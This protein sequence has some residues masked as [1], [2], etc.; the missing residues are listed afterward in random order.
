MSSPSLIFFV[1]SPVQE[2]FNKAVVD[3][4]RSLVFSPTTVLNILK[5]DPQLRSDAQI[6]LLIQYLKTSPMS[7]FCDQL[8]QVCL[9]EIASCVRYKRLRRGQTLYHKGQPTRLCYIVMSGSFSAYDSKSPYTSSSIDD[10]GGGAA[11]DDERG[12]EEEEEEEEEEQSGKRGT[13]WRS[14]AS[15]K[16]SSTFNT[17]PPPVQGSARA[18]LSMMTSQ[19]NLFTTYNGGGGGEERNNGSVKIKKKTSKKNEIK[20]ESLLKKTGGGAL[21]RSWRTMR[22]NGVTRKSLLPYRPVSPVSPVLT[23]YQTGRRESYTSNDNNS[24]SNHSVEEGLEGARRSTNMTQHYPRFNQRCSLMKYWTAAS[25]YDSS[26]SSSFGRGGPRRTT[27]LSL[28]ESTTSNR[29]VSRDQTTETKEQ[30]RHE[31]R[32]KKRNKTYFEAVRVSPVRLGD[33][34]KEED[35]VLAW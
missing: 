34:R 7:L 3:Y 22:R 33:I 6:D 27:S 14:N 19:S 4:G 28:A 13:T 23:F 32:K 5:L 25:V 20:R 17:S 29:R 2:L 12:E 30:R 24:S 10:E 18:R 16:I 8:P 31:R 21:S 11:A 26:M 9:K 15:H 1:S 35:E